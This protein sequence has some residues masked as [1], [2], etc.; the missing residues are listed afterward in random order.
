MVSET[1]TLYGTK[2][3][4]RVMRTSENKRKDFEIDA[5]APKSADYFCARG[6]IFCC[7]REPEAVV[8]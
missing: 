6:F 2:S 7:S 1:A 3:F 4:M 5:S 8:K